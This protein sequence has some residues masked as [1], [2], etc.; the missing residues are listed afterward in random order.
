MTSEITTVQTKDTLIGTQ[1]REDLLKNPYTLWFTP[2]YG[3]YKPNT[4]VIAELKKHIKDVSVTVFMGTWCDDS[5]LQVPGFFKILDA[6]QF[7]QA[8]VTL[9]A[10]DKNKTTPEKF[11]KGLDMTNVPT[12]IFYKNGKE[13]HRIVERPIQTLEEDMLKILSGQSYKHAYQY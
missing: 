5:Q 8:N 4:T 6:L 3:N 13:I 11:E 12:F 10:V 2:N 7:N 1:T 9:I